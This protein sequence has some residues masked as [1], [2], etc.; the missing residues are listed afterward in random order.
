MWIAGCIVAVLIWVLVF[1]PH[2]IW[3]S[4]TGTSGCL[5]TVDTLKF[6]Q[7][8]ISI[9]P[10]S[11]PDELRLNACRHYQTVISLHPHLWGINSARAS[12]TYALEVILPLE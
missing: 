10:T 6:S 5:E 4:L 2:S 3:D 12:G 8:R 11:E 1:N 9:L 7:L